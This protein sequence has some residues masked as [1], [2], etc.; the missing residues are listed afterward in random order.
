MLHFAKDFKAKEQVLGYI[1]IRGKETPVVDLFRSNGE[2]LL[3]E[4]V[5]HYEKFQVL[6]D[7]RLTAQI[8]DTTSTTFSVNEEWVIFLS[9]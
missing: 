3:A 5:S 4:K 6:E 7:G 9:V 8:N 1:Q 2:K